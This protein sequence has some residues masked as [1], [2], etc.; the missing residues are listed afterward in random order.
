MKPAREHLQSLRRGIRLLWVMQGH[1]FEGLRLKQIADELGVTSCTALRDLEAL[2]DEGV[3]E[4]IPGREEHWRLTPKIVQI[5][6]AHEEE[7]GRISGRLDQFNQ[8]YTRL[9]K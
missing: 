2:A 8:R 6:R 1:S 5:A 7:V 3:V 4:R 9:P